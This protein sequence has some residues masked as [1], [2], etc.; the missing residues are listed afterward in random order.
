MYDL[1]Y[2]CSGHRRETCSRTAKPM[3]GQEV[4]TT[5]KVAIREDVYSG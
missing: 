2:R 3:V 4:H 5:L 1:G